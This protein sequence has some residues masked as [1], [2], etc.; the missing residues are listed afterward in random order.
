MSNETFQRADDGMIRL[1]S[2]RADVERDIALLRQCLEDRHSILAGHAGYEDWG[3]SKAGGGQMLYC[4]SSGSSDKAKTIRRTALSWVQTFRKTRSLFHLSAQDPYA[5]LGAL[6]HSLTLYGIL[7][8]LEVGGGVDVLTGLTP[9]HQAVALAQAQSAVLYATPSQLRLLLEGAKIAQITL[10]VMKLIWSGGGK[11]D[12]DC[13]TGLEAL[14]PNGQI[15]EFYGASETSLITLSDKET[16]VGSV[17]KAYP[18]VDV[19]IRDADGAVL[20]APGQI[21]EIWI[22]SPYLFDGYEVG[23]SRDT[24]WRDGY[25]TVGEMGSLDANGFLFLKG[26]KSRMVT[27]AD[28][29]VFLEDVE[30]VLQSNPSV[31]ICAAFAVPD[32]HRGHVVMAIVERTPSAASDGEDAGTH[33]DPLATHLQAQCRAVLGPLAT[34]KAVHFIDHLPLLPAGK[35]DLL[36]LSEWLEGILAK[37]RP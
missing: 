26:R 21:G 2:G 29:N 33:V 32:K 31:R 4:Q 14:C 17:G 12:P 13:R 6:S 22:K 19:Q 18:G 27:V 34:P 20:S 3:K 1:A 9:R 23:S 28:Q 10:P 16:P 24:L 30:A 8:G 35:P 11:L 15:L 37:E 36:A 25:L 5:V 7:E